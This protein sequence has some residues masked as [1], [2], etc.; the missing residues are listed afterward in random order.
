MNN[1]TYTYNADLRV[2]NETIT[3]RDVKKLKLLFDFMD[4][5]IEH[6]PHLRT[7]MVAY[8]T[9]LRLRNEEQK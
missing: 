9:A 4:Y 3:E 7:L 6:D 2:G 5:V 8:K 1:L